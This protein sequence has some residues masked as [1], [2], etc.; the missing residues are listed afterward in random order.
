MTQIRSIFSE[1]ALSA[2]ICGKKIFMNSLFDQNCANEIKQRIG[3]LTPE[4]HAEWGKMNVGQMVCH[5]ADG[6]RMALGEREVADRSSFMSK[7][8]LKFLVLNVI[9]VPKGVPTAP[10]LDQMRDGTP[11]EDFEKDRATLI[12]TI[13]ELNSKPIDY[14]WSAH[15]KFGPMSRDRKSVV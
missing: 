14:A 1:S 10:E 15:A 5:V 4:S 6:Y 9:K 12:A 7:T 3:N 13:D 8:L 2:Q 11:P